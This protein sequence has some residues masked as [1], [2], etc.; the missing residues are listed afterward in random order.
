MV[1]N[2]IPS[3]HGRRLLKLVRESI[4]QRLG[5]V[6]AV[7]QRG[8][9]DEALNQDL[10]SFVT[11][12]IDGRLRG[13]I[14]NL[15]PTGPLLGSLAQNARHAAFNDH[16]FSPLKKEEFERV[17]I[18]ISILSKPAQLHFDNGND[19]LTKLRPGTDGVILKKGK[20]RATFLPQVWK[21]L[22]Q[23]RLFMEHL[24]QKAGLS[25]TAWRDKNIEIYLYQ[26]QSFDEETD[27][28]ESYPR[29]D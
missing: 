21:Q 20:A 18:D 29:A 19:L 25:P 11:L 3:V 28:V 10:A 24:C 27:A 2:Q 17:S 15:E 9:E 12:K 4:A 8:L 6:E 7:D 1:S 22:P 5:M 16:R 14:G 13:C 23:P 26:V